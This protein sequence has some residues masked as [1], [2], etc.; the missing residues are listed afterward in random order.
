LFHPGRSELD[1]RCNS[2]EF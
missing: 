1:A 2:L